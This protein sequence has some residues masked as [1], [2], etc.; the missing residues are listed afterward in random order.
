MKGGIEEWLGLYGRWDSLSFD[1]TA[2]EE[3][4]HE[5][6]VAI[7]TYFRDILDDERS[8]RDRKENLETE[9]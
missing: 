2:L 3:I 8:G 1:V 4:I 9:L 5:G 7:A 6:R